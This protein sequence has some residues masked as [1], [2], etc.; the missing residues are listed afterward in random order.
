MKSGTSIYHYRTKNEQFVQFFR[1][2]ED[3][4]YRHDIDSLKNG[5]QSYQLNKLKYWNTVYQR[6]CITIPGILSCDKTFEF[7]NSSNYYLQKYYYFL[8]DIIL[9]L[10]FISAY[11]EVDQT[12]FWFVWGEVSLGLTVKLITRAK[13]SR[14]VS[15]I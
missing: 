1:Q 9:R 11:L 8:N 6:I 7:N 10:L 5:G 13:Y 4:V 3:F 15:V 14:V 2:K 12:V